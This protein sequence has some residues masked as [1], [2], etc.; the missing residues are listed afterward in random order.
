MGAVHNERLAHVEI[1]WPDGRI[2]KAGSWPELETNIRISQWRPFKN[3]RAFRKEMQARA[4]AWSGVR[5]PISGSSEVFL[6][7]LAGA[8]MFLVVCNEPDTDQDQEGK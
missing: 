3:R 1:I 7:A 2:S 6:N 8:G 5:V 4:M